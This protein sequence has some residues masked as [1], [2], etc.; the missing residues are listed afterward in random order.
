MNDAQIVDFLNYI[1]R[2]TG[3]YYASSLYSLKRVSM[4][5]IFSAVCKYTNKF[6]EK[7]LHSYTTW[8]NKHKLDFLLAEPECKVLK[9]Q[10]QKIRFRRLNILDG[11]YHGN[12]KVTRK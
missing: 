9:G 1:Y 2:P 8:C 3:E 4:R 12:N 7:T 10:Y 11:K 6:D 5:E